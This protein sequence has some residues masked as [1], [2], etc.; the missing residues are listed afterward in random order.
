M[1]HEFGFPVHIERDDY[2]SKL[3]ER[4]MIYLDEGDIII[5]A[6]NGLFDNLYEQ[7]LCPVVSHLLQAGLRLQEIAELLATRAQEVGRS[8]TVRS[9]FADAAQAA[10]YVGYTGGKLDDVAVIVSLVQCSSTSPL[11]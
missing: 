11:S 3:A 7:E 2:P 10:G 6:T 1:V 4:Y 9:P 8:A 5:A